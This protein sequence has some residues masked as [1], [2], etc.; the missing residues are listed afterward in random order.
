M[1]NLLAQV[2]SQNYHLLE[3]SVINARA[4]TGTTFVEYLKLFYMSFL[5]LVVL[6]SVLMIVWGGLSYITSNI[7]WVKYDAKGKIK[8]A[9]LGLLIALTS[10]LIL[11]TINPDLVSWNLNLTI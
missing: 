9:I 2:S 3:P 11:Y 8:N 4:D 1:K 5:S 7:P 6:L 10:W